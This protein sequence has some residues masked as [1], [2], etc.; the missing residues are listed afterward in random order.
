MCRNGR[1]AMWKRQAGLEAATPGKHNGFASKE[2]YFFCR[3]VLDL[4]F[5]I[6]IV[7]C[8]DPFEEKVCGHDVVVK[9]PLKASLAIFMCEMDDGYGV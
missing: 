6:Y 2:V 1:E 4:F 5:F 8:F 7:P 9:I 3:V